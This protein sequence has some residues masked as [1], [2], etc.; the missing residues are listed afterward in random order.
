MNVDVD[1]QISA[2]TRKLGDRPGEDGELLEMTISQA[3]DTDAADLWDCVT[4][5]ERIARW[6]MPV[7]GDLRLGGKYQLEGNAGGTVDRCDPPRS[8]NAT[9]EFGGGVSWIE[10]VITAEDDGRSRFTLVHTAKVDEQLWDVYGPGAVGVG[11][12]GMVLGLGLYLGSG[13]ANDPAEAEAW[14][15]TDEGRRFTR[16]SSD[17]WVEAAIAYGRDPE[18]ARAAGEKTVEFYTP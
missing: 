14:S 8:F 5:G 16:L 12:D 1:T 13:E 10:V 2:V 7:S 6:F 15:G 18:K 4:N 3:Y 9:W 17:A 11:W